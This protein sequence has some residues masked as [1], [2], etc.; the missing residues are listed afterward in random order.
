MIRAGKNYGGESSSK[1]AETRPKT[2]AH[3]EFETP[4]HFWEESPKIAALLKE[5]KNESSLAEEDIYRIALG[6]DEPDD[7]LETPVKLFTRETG[8]IRSIRTA[9]ENIIYLIS[10]LRNGALIKAELFKE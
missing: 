7:T 9:D 6:L 4:I 5:N 10:N 3:T 1:K 2:P 8:H